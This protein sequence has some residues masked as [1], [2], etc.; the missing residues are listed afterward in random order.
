MLT[1]HWEDD[2]WRE[3]IL[4]AAGVLGV[5]DGHQ[6][7]ASAYVTSL[8]QLEPVDP[9][10]TGRG[11]VLAGRALADIGQRNV[12]QIT[13]RDVMRDL[14]LTMQDLHPDTERPNDPPVV[15]PR[16]RYAAGEAW[17][18]LGG[19]P[20]DLDAWV[21]CPKCADGG[22]D[23]LASKY[24][25]T[26]VQFERFIKDEGYE[27]PNWWGGEKSIGWQWRVKST[28]TT[29]GEEQVT[30]PEYWQRSA[31]RQ[32][33]PRLP[34]GRRLLVRGRGVCR[35]AGGA[36]ARLQGCTGCRCGAN[37]QLVD[38]EPATWNLRPASA[39]RR[40]MAASG[41]RREGGQEGALS[42]GRAG[43]RPRHRLRKGRRPDSDPGAGEHQRI[44]HRRHVAGGDVPV[45]REQAVRACGTWPAMSGNGPTRGTIRS[46]ETVWCVGGRGTTIRGV[47]RPVRP[48]QERSGLLEL[49]LSAFGWSPPLVLDSDFWEKEMTA[50][51][52]D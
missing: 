39:H 24:P 11:A 43:E 48:R 20:D 23:L 9:A 30:Q 36:V 34:G 35:V 51:Q 19:L 47:A 50:N 29:V 46:R 22:G 16:L 15:V 33:P 32:R 5:V 49:Q 38:L 25:V 10:N 1:A 42:L 14:R 27:N 28:P 7:D 6:S 26:N 18:E 40:R 44:R 13:R 45:G 17:D 4:L 41:R 12:N 31:F 37:G 52:P 3:V 21:L 2:R 8:R